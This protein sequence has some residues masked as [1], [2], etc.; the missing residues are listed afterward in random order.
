M[1]KGRKKLSRYNTGSMSVAP[2][3]NGNDIIALP[4]EE[5]QPEENVQDSDDEVRY[6]SVG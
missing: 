3:E 5:N 4:E 6:L 1:E 2:K